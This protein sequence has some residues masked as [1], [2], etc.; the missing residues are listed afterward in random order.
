MTF[1]RKV[2]LG[3]LLSFGSAIF[4]EESPN[5]TDTEKRIVILGDSITVGYGLSPKEAYPALLQKKITKAELPYTVANAGVSGD[6]TAG[7]LRRVHWAMAKGA[8]VLVIALGG[9]DGLRGIPPGE[10][11]KNLLGIITKA[12]AK[13]PKIK[14]LIAGMQM[15]DNMGP[16]FTAAFKTLFPDVASESKATL[17]PFLIEGVGGVEKLNQ[18]DGIHPTAEGQIKVADNVWKFLHPVISP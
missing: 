12:R 6:T 8:D 7:G 16:R 17:I 5:A 1:R 10:T 13:N 11:K 18:E 3:L 4:A 15:P 2:F 9:N 14:I